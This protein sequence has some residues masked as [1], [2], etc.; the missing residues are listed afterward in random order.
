MRRPQ[1]CA[2]RPAT[3]NL[4]PLHSAYFTACSISLFGCVGL[5]NAQITFTVDI[6]QPIRTHHILVGIIELYILDA[7]DCI[8]TLNDFG[9][10]LER[11]RCVIT[12]SDE[13]IVK[14]HVRSRRKSAGCLTK[15][16]SYD[17]LQPGPYFIHGAYFH[18]HQSHIVGWR[19]RCSD[20]RAFLDTELFGKRCG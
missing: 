11:I 5:D 8:R 6:C 13:L 3:T 10:C 12:T 1:A 20:T 15:L 18:V 17:K 9:C 16:F 4:H 7:I 2:D 19:T 14:T